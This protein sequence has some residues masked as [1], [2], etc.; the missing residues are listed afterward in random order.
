MNRY[1]DVIINKIRSFPYNRISFSAVILNSVIHDT[2]AVRPRSRV[3]HCRIEKYSYI[4][5]ECL[6]QNVQIG[7]FCSVSEGCYIGMPS[8]PIHYVSSSPVFLDGKNYLRTNFSKISYDDCPITF[9]GSDV[10]IGVNVLIKAGIKI[11]NGAIIGAGSVVTKDVPP[12]A[13]VGGTPARII[14]Y[15]FSDEI[16]QAFE[17]KRWW[18]SDDAELKK[19]AQYF[20]NPIELIKNL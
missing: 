8:H 11:G 13:I 18:E 20:D 4:S 3:Y 16:I 17:E 14:K 15:R 10:W 9:V 1:L 2:C 7:S 6:L 12:Y 5:R 19:K